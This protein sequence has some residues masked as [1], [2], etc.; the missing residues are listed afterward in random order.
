MLLNAL[1]CVGKAFA[2]HKVAHQATVLSSNALDDVRVEN[3]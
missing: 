2:H 1:S 3:V